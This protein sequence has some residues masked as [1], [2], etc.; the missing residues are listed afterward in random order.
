M[1]TLDLLI[2]SLNCHY[3]Y[4]T[5]TA[6]RLELRMK[7][8]ITLLAVL[9]LSACTATGKR[10]VSPYLLANGETGYELNVD[11]V[12]FDSWKEK[13]GDNWSKS[14]VEVLHIENFYKYC[15]QGNFKIVDNIEHEDGSLSVRYQCL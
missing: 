7:Q 6:F 5:I 12:Q 2:S 15:N 10:S 8:A 3:Q 11:K 1:R 14:M 13:D 9:A 4:A